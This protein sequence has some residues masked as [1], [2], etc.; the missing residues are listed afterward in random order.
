MREPITAF[1]A[2]A[3]ALVIAAPATAEVVRTSPLAG[4]LAPTLIR[5]RPFVTTGMIAP[6]AYVSVEDWVLA[7]PCRATTPITFLSLTVVVVLALLAPSV[8]TTSPT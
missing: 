4:A 3:P 2:G 8:I 1:A 6:A 5:A 7:F